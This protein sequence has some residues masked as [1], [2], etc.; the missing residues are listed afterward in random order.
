MKSA[1]VARSVS[2]SR[3]SRRSAERSTPECRELV[4]EA[5]SIDPPGHAV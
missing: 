5:G 3:S 1:T 2:L 4:G